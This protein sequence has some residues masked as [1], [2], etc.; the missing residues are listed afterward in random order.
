MK[1]QLLLNALAYALSIAVV[2]PSMLDA[3]PCH[4]R[5]LVLRKNGRIEKVVHLISDVHVQEEGSQLEGSARIGK[6]GLK[7]IETLRRIGNRKNGPIVELL[8]ESSP[9]KRK[10]FNGSPEENF[11]VLA[12]CPREI[13]DEFSPLQ[14]K[15]LIY[16]DADMY[17]SSISDN[18]SEFDYRKAVSFM[19]SGTIERKISELKSKADHDTIAKIDRFGQTCKQQMSAFF[20]QQKAKMKF[21]SN[22]DSD[23]DDGDDSLCCLMDLELLIKIFNSPYAHN[24]VYA[25]GEHCNNLCKELQEQFNFSLV[26]EK[27]T[28]V[29]FDS[30][31]ACEAEVK[32]MIS[33]APSH[34]RRFIELDMAKRLAPVPL[35]LEVW[36]DLFENIALVNQDSTHNVITNNN[37]VSGDAELARRLQREEERRL[38][39]NNN[40]PTSRPQ[41]EMR[42]PINNQVHSDE[43][44]ARRLQEKE[45][46]LATRTKHAPAVRPKTTIYPRS[47]NNQ[48]DKD[49]ALA[50]QLQ[51]DEMH[52]QSGLVATPRD[53][54]D[55]ATR[56]LIQR[57]LQGDGN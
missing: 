40:V 18:D 19:K 7:F 36:N 16:S 15:R 11:L 37:N 46:R 32:R 13:C 29:S 38:S 34:Q 2:T 54:M 5:K 33:E 4:Y 42:R 56:A 20:E 43:E 55:E 12:R 22:E 8:F 14:K 3:Y 23:D 31:D 50:L 28:K 35:S 48:T 57:M 53:D 39:H 10:Y 44:F 26:E 41:P 51:Q 21:A 27:G 45:R 17:R 30:L 25:G 1:K 47:N 6:S 49:A 9:D 24:I 52:K